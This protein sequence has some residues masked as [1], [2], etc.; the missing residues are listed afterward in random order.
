[1]TG[2]LCVPAAGEGL[3]DYA[4]PPTADF[5]RIYRMLRD[6]AGFTPEEVRTFLAEGMLLNP[7]LGLRL[8]EQ[9]GTDE[10]TTELLEC[11]FQTKLQLVLD[12]VGEDAKEPATA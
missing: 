11:T 4:G 8:P 9:Y 7:L 10:A 1:M 2:A 3:S 5:L 12:V 6:D